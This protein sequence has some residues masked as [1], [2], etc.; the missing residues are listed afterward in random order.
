ML[1]FGFWIYILRFSLW[2]SDWV[3]CF[4]FPKYPD[5]IWYLI[6]MGFYGFLSRCKTVKVISRYCILIILQ[7]LK[8]KGS[9]CDSH[10][11]ILFN[12]RMNI[13]R[14]LFE[15]TFGIPALSI[16]WEICSEMHRISVFLV[17]LIWKYSA[18]NV[19]RK[20]EKKK[21]SCAVWENI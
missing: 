14:H 5:C 13:N 4:P 9:L 18:R 17:N 11:L 19:K 10:M 7:A 16:T 20:K 3:C 15:I 12:C 8:S 1:S 21:L 6:W 2:D